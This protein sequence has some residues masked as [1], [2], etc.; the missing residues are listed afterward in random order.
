MIIAIDPGKSGAVAHLHPDGRF[1][2]VHDMPDSASGLAALIRELISASNTTVMHAILE[3]VHAMP[4][5]GVTSM[6]TFG[7]G[8]GVIEGVLAYARIPC[9]QI[10]PQKWKREMGLGNKTDKEKSRLVALSLFPGSSQE[11]R[12][13]KHEGRAE[14]MLLGLWFA[15]KLGRQAA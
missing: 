7:K 1:C 5:Q 6:F 12:L 15:R 11:L 14:A 3:Q 4:G 2:C 10:S 9:E 13:K 8:V